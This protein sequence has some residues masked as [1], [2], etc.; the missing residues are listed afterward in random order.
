M[1]G[2][3][4]PPDVERRLRNLQA[5]ARHHARPR[6]QPGNAPLQEVPEAK[7]SWKRH[8]LRFGPIGALV[9]FALGKLKLIVPLL[10]FANL[11]TLLSMLVMVWVYAVYWGLPFAVGFVLLIFVHEAGHAIVMRRLG[12]QAGA[13]VFIP[14]VG[15]VI[16]MK[17]LPRDAYVEALVGIGGPVLGSVGALFCLV[18]ALSTGSLLWY[19]LAST[20]FLINLFNLIPVSPL[21]GGRIVGV[22]SRWLWA[23][24]YAVGIF[25]FVATR[26]PI[27]MLILVLG[28]FSLPRVVRGPREGYFD[29]PGSKRLAMGVAYFGLVAALSVAMWIADRPLEGMRSGPDGLHRPP[30]SG[31][32]GRAR[33]HPAHPS[34]LGAAPFEVPLAHVVQEGTMVEVMEDEGPIALDGLRRVGLP[35]HLDPHAVRDLVQDA[36]HLAGQREGVADAGIAFE[37][38][39]D[40][41]ADVGADER[42]QAQPPRVH[43]VDFRGRRRPVLDTHANRHR[44]L[45]PLSEPA[46]GSPGGLVRHRPPLLALAF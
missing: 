43:V 29:V 10:K 9:L 13:P 17:S 42:L 19:S 35:V 12:L 23:A 26:S 38:D 6:G 36:H 14:F 30:A 40:T 18:V 15:A 1:N 45:Q 7:S 33:P 3:L 24:G 22:I 37:V 25:V 28:L 5:V 46:I 41:V 32:T 20:G 44:Q 11:G 27:L 8:L 34:A 16:A 2:P 39:G 31:A 4:P 21:D